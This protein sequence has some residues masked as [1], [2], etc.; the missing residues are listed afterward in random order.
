MRLL[1]FLAAFGLAAT[2]L[3]RAELSVTDLRADGWENP[4]GL[5]DRFPTFSWRLKSEARGA[6]Q[7][8]AQILV[9][10]SPALL[11][12]GKADLWDSGRVATDSPLGLRYA[13]RPLGSSL[14]AH[15]KVRV[16]DRA[17]VPSAWS[18]VATLTT[19]M[20]LPEDWSPRARWISD[21]SLLE[22][23]R[24]FL[25]FRT[26]GTRDESAAEWVQVDLGQ[27]LAIDSV[28][29]H[30]I[31]HGAP[32]RIGFPRRYR[33]EIGDDPNFG[34]GRA[35]VDLAEDYSNA[36][37]NVIT[38]PAQGAT[39]RFVRVTATKLR[40]GDD[41]LACFA[42]RQLEILSGGRNVAAGRLV[43]A[44]NSVEIAPW[45][46]NGVVDGLGL[47]AVNPRANGTLLLQREFTVRPD[48]RRAVLHV[49]GLGHYTLAVNGT[50]VGD[51]RLTPGWTRT[52]Q[53]IL[54]D[55]HDLTSQ[56]RPG[57]NALGLTLAG[58][59]FNVSDGRYVKFITEFHPPVA[60]GQLVLH[61]A[62]GSSDSIVTDSSWR[63]APGPTTFA[64]MFG[65]EDHDARLEPAGWAR[66]GFTGPDWSPAVAV[67]APGGE[68]R[69]LAHAAPPI[70]THEIFAAPAPREIRPGVVVHDFKQNA[71]IM[72]RL[73]VSGPAGSVV[74]IIPA[75]LL[76]ADGTVDRR[77]VGGSAWWQYTLRGDTAGEA[78]EPA[79]FY[80]GARY[81]QV[82]LTPA[83]D[84]TWPR[85][86]SL[87]A[88][89]IH[90]A[91]PPA[92]E[93]ECSNELFNRIY[94]LVRWAQRSNLQHVLTDCP[95]RERLGWLEQYH[96]NGPALRYNW[97]LGRH[98]TKTF[99]DMAD[100][101]T[102]SGLVP[103]I[104]PDY[105]VFDGGFRDSPEWGS[106]LILAARQHLQWTGDVRPLERHYPAMQRYLAYLGTR[107]TDGHILDHGLGDW[108]DLGPNRPGVA[109]LTPIALTATAIYFE[110]A[111]TLALIARRLGHESDAGNYARLA[112]AIAAD[113]QRKFFDPAKGVYAGGSQT[114]QAM[115]LVL[116]LVP[117]AQRTSVLAALVRDIEQRGFANSAGD[118]GYRYVLRALADAGRSDVI[119][120]MTNQSEKPGYG[121]QLAQGATS[122]T[123]AWDADRRVSQ[124]HFMLGQINEWFFHDLAGIQPGADGEGF[125][126][127]ILAPS[128]VEG[129]DAVRASHLSPFGWIRSEWRR[130]GGNVTYSVTVPPGSN[131]TVRL[132]VRHREDI[133]ESGR[134]LRQAGLDASVTESGGISIRVSSG[135]YEFS[136]PAR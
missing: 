48:L 70:K 74:K 64:N 40:R 32:E 79:F 73:K 125:K 23:R 87:E 53:T 78:W 3:S 10:S 18:P 14:A 51:A 108:Y 37:A 56:L 29:L 58:G 112:K 118:V 123:E 1:A 129:L 114:A 9:A 30:A 47:P 81:L 28:R 96:L 117:D 22:F 135:S 93:F 107:A 17:G 89:V 65:G 120:Q 92:G 20:V 124:N 128:F 134:S 84:G 98:F 60:F 104:A 109:Q 83:A 49:T 91:A 130:T 68:L 97:D 110:D 119:Y 24:D 69:G 35:V 80:H 115:P 26:Q 33:L 11:A 62:D 13:G 7:S 71:A 94:H 95:H 54:Y 75:E 100:A 44:S 50:K 57:A 82:E 6:A 41:G 88:A 72:P 42:L 43:S 77:N 106:A 52:D 61:Y 131:A 102:E 66:A 111:Q 12:E 90:S 105:V 38:V 16:W 5:D 59:M 27:S 8:A 34:D 63:V 85:V 4:I 19:G 31:R 39:G 67:P 2:G 136:W 101:Q 55:T 46:L 21:P 132:P 103:G 133:R 36:W 127:F 15:W 126:E 99:Q 25:G 86:E 121:Y 76:R 45:S 116:G 113:F 122:L